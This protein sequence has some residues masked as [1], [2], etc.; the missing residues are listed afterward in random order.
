MN[1][2]EEQL[3]LFNINF[4]N[5]FDKYISFEDYFVGIVLIEE[6]LII[7]LKMNRNNTVDI[8][9]WDTT[10]VTNIKNMFSSCV[11]LI[12]FDKME[13]ERKTIDRE[14]KINQLLGETIK[15]N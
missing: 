7:G 11:S 13:R 3:K 12:D 5:E 10:K 15:N 6:D 8:S 1:S 4:W 9:N 14:N 2:E